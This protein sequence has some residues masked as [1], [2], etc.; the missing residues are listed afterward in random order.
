[1]PSDFTTRLDEIDALMYALVERW[2]ANDVLA[3]FQDFS[4]GYADARLK[5][6]YLLLAG[7]A[8]SIPSKRTASGEYNL[9]VFQVGVAATTPEEVGHYLRIVNEWTQNAP[10]DL[11]AHGYRLK[12]ITR[13]QRTKV[14]DTSYWIT[15]QEYEAEVSMEAIRSPA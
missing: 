14:Q 10:L 11:T 15:W 1:M 12:R 7:D 4:R 2:K 3:K 5:R 9:V 8:Q 13:R 6:P